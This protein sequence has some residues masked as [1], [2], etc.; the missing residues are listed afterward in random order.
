MTAKRPRRR[1]LAKLVAHHILGDV[2][3]DELVAVVDGQCVPDEI[4]GD[5]RSSGPRSNDFLVARFVQGFNL[6]GQMLVDEGA[7]LD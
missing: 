5:R 6:L 7:L 4:W 1:K 3:G 2:D